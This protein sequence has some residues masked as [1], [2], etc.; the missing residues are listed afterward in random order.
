MTTT[1][2]TKRDRYTALIDILK[3]AE[4]VDT[5]LVEFCENEIALLDKKAAKAKETAATKKTEVDPLTEAIKDALAT[6]A[7]DVYAITPEVTA[8][9]SV[10]DEDITNAKVSYRLSQLV[11]TGEAESTDVK[12]PATEGS[13]ARTIKG[14]RLCV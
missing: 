8:M 2:T 1:K 13:K 14:Y 11:K 9:V 10:G 7:D 12:V 5:D 4:V 6:L 3:S